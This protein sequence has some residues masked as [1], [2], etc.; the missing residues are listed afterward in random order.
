MTKTD[1]TT[2]EEWNYM[3]RPRQGKAS[4]TASSG[5]TVDKLTAAG[6]SVRVKH[7]RYAV[8]H[9]LNE[10]LINKKDYDFQLRKIVVPSTFRRDTMYALLPK[11]GFTHV[12]IK[13]SSGKYICVSSECSEEDPF[14]YSKGV[15][16]ALERLTKLDM[17]LLGV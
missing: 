5:I 8:Y 11:G 17:E 10:K 4:F 6:N 7:L 16:T 13:H 15:A 14:C 3:S 12:V 9:G 1:V 2:G